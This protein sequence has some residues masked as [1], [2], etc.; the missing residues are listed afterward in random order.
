MYNII[1]DSKEMTVNTDI[2]IVNN[3]FLSH[4]DMATCLRINDCFPGSILNFSRLNYIQDKKSIPVGSIKFIQ[5][6][7]GLSMQKPEYQLHS[8]LEVP[9]ELRV[10]EFLGRKYSVG[11]VRDNKHNISSKTSYFVKTLAPVDCYKNILSGSEL[12]ASHIFEDVNIIVSGVLDIKSEWRVFVLNGEIVNLACYK[13]KNYSKMPDIS[14]V[15]KMIQ[16]YTNCPPAYVLDVAVTA[17]GTFVLEAYNF[18]GVEL[19]STCWDDS[20]LEMLVKGYE[21]EVSLGDKYSVQK[22]FFYMR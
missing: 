22:G 3:C 11:T 18:L 1:L 7:I 8:R 20:L 4:K 14:A 17:K 9:D 15:T 21:W 12:V 13:A 6:A 10:P 5:S 19:Y 2:Q 16:A